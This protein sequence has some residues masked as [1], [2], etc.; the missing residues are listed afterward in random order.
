[1]F[2]DLIVV[3]KIY[4]HIRSSLVT[5]TLHNVICQLCLSKAGKKKI[6]GCVEMPVILLKS[7]TLVSRGAK[8][9]KY[10]QMKT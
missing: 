7:Q 8:K 10:L 1:M 2:T 6:R 4:K 3:F 9:V 5:L